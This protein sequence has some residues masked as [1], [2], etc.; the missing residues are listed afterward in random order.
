MLVIFGYTFTLDSGWSDKGQIASTDFGHLHVLAVGRHETRGALRVGGPT[1][2]E[3]REIRWI[4]IVAANGY[5][6]YSFGF[7]T[8]LGYRLLAVA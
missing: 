4:G 7:L 8:C 6:E 1:K 2:C 3:C 5:M